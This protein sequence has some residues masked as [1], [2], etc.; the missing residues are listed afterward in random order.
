MLTKIGY[1]CENLALAPDE[2]PFLLDA[3][4]GP[5]PRSAVRWVWE[6]AHRV[7]SQLAPA[8]AA[9][10]VSWLA[11]DA[12]HRRAVQVLEYGSV[13]LYGVPD[14]EV[15]YLFSARPVHAAPA[16][17]DALMSATRPLRIT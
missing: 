6:R 9:E 1:W 8:P 11:A 5:T 3:Y 17:L 10:V 14:D 4:L 2:D 12:E 7:A 15:H 16:Q 13:Y